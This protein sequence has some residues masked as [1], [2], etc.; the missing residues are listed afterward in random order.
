[1]FEMQEVMI[2]YRQFQRL[3][4]NGIH[5]C[6]RPGLGLAVGMH[7]D[8]SYWGPVGYV[9]H[10]SPSLKHAARRFAVIWLRPSR[11]SPN[12]RHNRMSIWTRMGALSNP[13]IT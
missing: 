12:M 9:V 7:F 8:W 4:Y 2:S 5:L 3:L 11:Y 6:Q 1:M 13:L 10:C